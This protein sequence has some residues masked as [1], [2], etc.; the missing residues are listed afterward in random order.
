MV[1]TTLPLPILKYLEMEPEAIE[2][3]VQEYPF[4]LYPRIAQIL[5]KNKLES[6]ELRQLNF[7]GLNDIKLTSYINSFKT[8]EF[9]PVTA[10]EEI[11]DVS[12]SSE[13]EV[14]LH[15]ISIDIFEK[16]NIESKPVAQENSIAEPIDS[17][18]EV[19]KIGLGQT[20]IEKDKHLTLGHINPIDTIENSLDIEIDFSNDISDEEL[21]DSLSNIEEDIIEIP[22]LTLLNE[23]L[24]LEPLDIEIDFLDT[25]SDEELAAKLKNDEEHSLKETLVEE[26]DTFTPAEQIIELDKL[27]LNLPELVLNESIIFETNIDNTPILEPDSIEISGTQDL[28]HTEEETQNELTIPNDSEIKDFTD[29]LASFPQMNSTNREDN[30][31]K[32]ETTKENNDEVE[33]NRSIQANAAQHLLLES[34]KEDSD[35][36]TINKDVELEGVL[37]DNFFKTQVEIKKVSRKTPSE[38]RIQDE[39][40][41]SLQPLDLVSETMAILHEKQG[42][43]NKAIE[44][45]EKLIALFPE[46]SS[47]FALQIENLRK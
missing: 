37:K 18:S 36:P 6:S 19:E 29:W 22:E 40:Q 32:L 34:F 31:L 24:A 17:I 46:K 42:N 25:I 2:R 3:I 38:L 9:S 8:F 41:L 23:N 20:Y 30:K 11:I 4:Y 12:V 35:T 13:P 21:A 43:I 39:A 26:V 45:Y 27:S 14:S 28:I 16:S 1:N 47:F 44:I 5:S 10:S 7:F 33:L 15:D